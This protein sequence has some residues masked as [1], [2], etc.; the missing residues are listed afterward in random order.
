MKRST[1]LKK[2]VKRMETPGVITS[3]AQFPINYD[4]A[5]EIVDK[6]NKNREFAETV[7]NRVNEVTYDSKW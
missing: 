7:I 2:L 5:K 4:K 3:R 6:R 1:A